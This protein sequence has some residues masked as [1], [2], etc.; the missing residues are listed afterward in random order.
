MDFWNPVNGAVINDWIEGLPLTPNAQVLDIGCG[1]AE[2]LQ[3]VHRRHSCTCIGVDPS[4]LAL[5]AALPANSTSDT[6]PALDLRH[7]AFHADDFQAAQ[8]DVIAC[9]G[10][11][12]AVG[13]TEACLRVLGNLLRS[14][15]RLWLGIGYWRREPDQGYLDYLQCKQEE[16]LS[17][18]GNVELFGRHRWRVECHHLTSAE[19]WS[20]YEDTY[21]AN[22]Q[23]HLADHP[24]D[25]DFAAMKQR[26]DGWR[27]AYLQWGR[28]TL[29]FAMYL[30]R[31]DPDEPVES[32]AGMLVDHEPAPSRL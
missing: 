7:Q 6:A 24:E 23:Q 12:H 21:A 17:H 5:A 22:I 14:N 4:A 3:R 26:I 30:L 19:E 8:F 15:G 28:T 1:R 18:E 9:I 2:W 20:Q 16:M 13:D 32:G 27:R 25:P 29:G 10:S 11:T 31:S